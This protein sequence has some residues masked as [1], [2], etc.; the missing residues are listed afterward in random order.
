MGYTSADA[1][2]FDDVNE[3][4]KLGVYLREE[5]PLNGGKHGRVI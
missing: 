3:L 1:I 5:D 4:I 2:L